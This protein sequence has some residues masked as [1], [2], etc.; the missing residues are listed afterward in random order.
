MLR[1]IRR[2]ALLFFVAGTFTAATALAQVPQPF[3]R[4]GQQPQQRPVDQTVTPPVV[5]P[6][7]TPGAVP[8]EAEVGAPIYPGAEFIASYDAGRG[9]RY[10]LFGTNADFTQ[11]V[12]YYKT[13][14]KD[15]GDRVYDEPP[16]HEFDT[17]RF[18]EDSMAFPPG[19]TVKDYTWGGSQGYL[20]PKRG[21]E[22][23]RF[24]TIIQIVPPPAGAAR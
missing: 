5:L 23:Q 2:A 24:R 16:I 6:P 20:N 15:G 7:P 18:R 17:V 3:P 4:P 9:Q 19:V 10:Y 1:G 14:L 22:P 11:I 8:D 21:A 12:N 13:V